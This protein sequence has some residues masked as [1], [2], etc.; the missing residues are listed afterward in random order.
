VPVSF[1]FGFI[2]LRFICMLTIA[3]LSISCSKQYKQQRAYQFLTMFYFTLYFPAVIV[4]RPISQG[5]IFTR[6]TFIKEFVGELVKILWSNLNMSPR[7][8]FSN[9]LL[10]KCFI[11]SEKSFIDTDFLVFYEAAK[12]TK[13]QI[14]KSIL[15]IA[16]VK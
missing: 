16:F 13:P 11:L 5:R 14:N 9:L 1:P 15:K 8:F 4:F 3:F 2:G 12:L 7:N 6:D 10:K